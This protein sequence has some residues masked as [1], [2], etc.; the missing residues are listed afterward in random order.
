MFAGKVGYRMLPVKT[1]GAICDFSLFSLPSRDLARA[2]DGCGRAVL[3]AATVGVGID[4]LI[5][6]YSRLS[7][8]KALLFQA[9]GAQ[10]VEA[11]CDAFC[12]DL[13]RETGAPLRQRFSP[14]YGDLALEVQ[15]EVFTILDGKRI[16]VSLSESLL[17]TP[18]KSVTAFVGIPGNG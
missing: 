1:D 2:L 5:A 11:V 17:M 8:A 14:G 12:A 15:R 10:Q 6:R 13:E 7:P 3:F 16:G 4:R 9:L 18:S